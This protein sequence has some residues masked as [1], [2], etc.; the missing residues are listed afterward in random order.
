M[1]IT[2]ILTLTA[3]QHHCRGDLR[4]RVPEPVDGAADNV[5]GSGHHARRAAGELG[6]A[7][8]ERGARQQARPTGSTFVESE[9]RPTGS[10]FV[11]TDA[12]VLAFLE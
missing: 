8:M 4:A 6:G 10:F 9:R 5:L 7:L 3:G 2:A 1:I 12:D 11:H